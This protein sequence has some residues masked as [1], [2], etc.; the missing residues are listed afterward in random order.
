VGAKYSDD[1]DEEEEITDT[2]NDSNIKKPD[3]MLNPNFGSA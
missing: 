1:K 2:P 3:P